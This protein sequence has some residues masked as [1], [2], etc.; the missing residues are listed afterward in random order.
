LKYGEVL[1]ISFFQENLEN[2]SKK[3][4]ICQINFLIF[5]LFAHL[6]FTHLKKRKEKEKEKDG[7]YPLNIG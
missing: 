3:E 2:F 1:S 5:F 7:T 6:N 4:R